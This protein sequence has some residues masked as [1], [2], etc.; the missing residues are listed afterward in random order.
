MAEVEGARRILEVFKQG[1]KFLTLRE[2]ARDA[3][4]RMATDKAFKLGFNHLIHEGIIV[5]QQ[6]GWRSE[7]R[8]GH[9]HPKTVVLNADLMEFIEKEY[10]VDTEAL[11]LSPLL[12]PKVEGKSIIYPLGQKQTAKFKEC[13]SCQHNPVVFITSKKIGVCQTHWDQL[14]GSRFTWS[15]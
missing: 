13:Q 2:L 7:K 5:L 12:A 11:E 4:F 6:S 9:N 8:G 1:K 15:S 10:S 14:G 3:G